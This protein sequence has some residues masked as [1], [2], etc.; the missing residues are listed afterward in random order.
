MSR[1]GDKAGAG[2]LDRAAVEAL[3]RAALENGGQ[4]ATAEHVQAV[5]PIA[6]KV[7]PPMIGKG[8]VLLMPSVLRS[9]H[10]PGAMRRMQQSTPARIGVGRVGTR[11]TTA[12]L[13][14]FRAD[15]AA[16]KE[17]VMSEV[18]P[19]LLARLGFV[20]VRSQA[21]DKRHFLQRP[22]AG[23]ALS[24]EGRRIVTERLPR[25]G[26][27][28]IIYGDGL[29]A[30]A[31]NTNLESLH[32]ALVKELGARG[33]AAGTPLYIHLS[34]V[35]IMDEV[36]RL[37]DSESAIFICGE[38]PG[39]GFADSL[40]AY[41]IYKPATGVTD[42]SLLRGVRFLGGAAG[43]ALHLQLR[44]LQH[45]H[46][47]LAALGRGELLEPD[48]CRQPRRAATDDHHV[49]FHRLARAVFGQQGGGGF[50]VR[51]WSVG[52]CSQDSTQA[53]SKIERSCF[54]C[55]TCHRTGAK[56]GASMALAPRVPG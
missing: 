25:G 37:T 18:R 41:Y 17:A 9:P 54:F 33:I 30:E 4:K 10:D 19:E 43:L 52:K 53:P 8:E 22:D 56:H 31:I 45:H 12:T 44:V 29:S 47:D 24:E 49:V 51:S 38:R 28:Q 40:S 15:H 20:E 5:K 26:R 50:Q 48:R 11:Y 46:R 23:R 14:K 39:L 21:S 7:P 6:G 32:A 42:G 36:A 55:R 3:V 13:L 35:K 16:A 2:A 1:P 34:R 27:L